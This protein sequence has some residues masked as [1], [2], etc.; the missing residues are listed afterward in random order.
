MPRRSLIFF[1]GVHHHR[2]SGNNGVN[3]LINEFT[4]PLYVADFIIKLGICDNGCNDACR[5]NRHQIIDQCMEEN[6]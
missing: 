2:S 3:N 5:R 4:S 1:L 6:Q